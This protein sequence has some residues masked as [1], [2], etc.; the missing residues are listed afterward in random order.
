MRDQVNCLDAG[1]AFQRCSQLR[2]A[3]AS[4]FE[5]NDLDVGCKTFEQFCLIGNGA[6]DDKN[7]S[8]KSGGVTRRPLLAECCGSRIVPE[9]VV[10][11][12][13]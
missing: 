13:A 6:V 4:G 10:S 1:A 7:L 11:A 12:V 9:R 3:V 5:P 2:Q 8:G